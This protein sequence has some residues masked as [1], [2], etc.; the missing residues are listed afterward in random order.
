MHISPVT[1][2]S[3]LIVGTACLGTVLLSI[4]P[5]RCADTSGQSSVFNLM[6]FVGRVESNGLCASAR[7]IQNTVLMLTPIPASQGVNLKTSKS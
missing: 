5:S 4:L 2:V 3:Q 1:A 7:V 6:M